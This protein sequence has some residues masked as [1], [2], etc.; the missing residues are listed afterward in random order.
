[1]DGI[2]VCIRVRHLEMKQ[3]PYILMLTARRDQTHE[4]HALTVGADDYMTKPFDPDLLIA[5]LRAL[6]RRNRYEN[7]RA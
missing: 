6:L 3:Y 1:M 5:R 4:I 2:K 7:C